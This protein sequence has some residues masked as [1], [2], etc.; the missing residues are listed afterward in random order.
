MKAI[1]ATL[2]LAVSATASADYFFTMNASAATPC[3]YTDMSVSDPDEV[4]SALEEAYGVD[5]KVT[6]ASGALMI[7]CK[8]R[9]TN[10]VIVTEFE[11]T[12]EMMRKGLVN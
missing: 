11:G 4:E 9:L 12:C 6:P 5:C 10:R 2:L 1:L 3:V 7:T 8:A